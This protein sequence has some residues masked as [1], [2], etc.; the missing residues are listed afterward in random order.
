MTIIQDILRELK[1]E[2]Q[3]FEHHGIVWIS[4]R[5]SQQFLESGKASY[6][7]RKNNQ[8]QKIMPIVFIGD[9]QEFF[10]HGM[11]LCMHICCG[12]INIFCS[13]RNRLEVVNWN[14]NWLLFFFLTL[15]I[16]RKEYSQLNRKKMNSHHVCTGICQRGDHSIC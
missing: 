16:I 2:V 12:I 7:Q 14:S 6:W 9:Y 13:I 11:K 4:K 1:T 5:C 8:I 10:I 15:L 3:V